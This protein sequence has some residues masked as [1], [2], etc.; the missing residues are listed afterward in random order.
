MYLST[1][2]PGNSRLFHLLIDIHVH[3]LSF[4][5]MLLSLTR[6]YSF[7]CRSHILLP[8]KFDMDFSKC[9][10]LLNIPSIITIN[11]Y[12]PAALR[13]RW[14]LLFSTQIHGESF[15]AFVHQIINQGPTVLV[16]QDCDGHIF[17]GFASKSWAIRSH[18]DGKSGDQFSNPVPHSGLRF[19]VVDPEPPNPHLMIYNILKYL[20]NEISNSVT[21][22]YHLV[23]A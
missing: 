20:E 17:G 19:A 7:C 18:F 15:Q 14:R 1:P 9:N 3:F 22:N 12:L 16:V 2:S 4:T 13:H 10:T 8:C 6:K 21:C 5:C 11:H 23:K